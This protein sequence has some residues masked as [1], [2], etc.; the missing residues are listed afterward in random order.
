MKKIISLFVLLFSIQFSIAQQMSPY[1][2]EFRLKDKS[3][4]V[5]EDT[6]TIDVFKFY[7]SNIKFK[8]RGNLVYNASHSY[9]LVNLSTDT[10]YR[11]EM[12]IPSKLS[13]DEI[14]FQL[15]IDSNTTK[16]G[17]LDGDLDPTK[18]MY[19]SWQSG[20]INIKLEGSSPKCKT[21]QH[22]YTFHL[23]GFLPHQYTEQCVRITKLNDKEA[24]VEINLQ[25]FFS[26][27]DLAK[28]NSVMIPGDK[29]ITLST[30][31]TTCFEH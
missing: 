15:G 29:A 27:V 19:W 25:K 2:I 7:M 18:G 17:I 26:V 11:V 8:D 6:I 21:R 12:S 1:G 5:Q 28:E 14:N 3:L 22:R 23:G 4:L 16:N 13:F 20:Y 30:K 24:I 31:I 10:F 9:H